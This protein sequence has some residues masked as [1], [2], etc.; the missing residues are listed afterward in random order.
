MIVGTARKDT[1]RF[2]FIAVPVLTLLA[3][4]LQ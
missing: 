4:L 1:F 2:Y 3:F